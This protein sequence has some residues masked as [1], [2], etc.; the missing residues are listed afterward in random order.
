MD[1]VKPKADDIAL[2]KKK[3]LFRPCKTK[4]DL[5]NWVITFLGVELPDCT[6]SPESNSNPMDLLWEMYSVALTNNDDDAKHVNRVM[7]YAARGAG[8]TLVASILELLVML[9]TRRNITHMAA[10]KDQA[11]VS[12]EYI[13]D[14]FD[15]PYIAPFRTSTNVMRLEIERYEHVETK[16]NLTRKE[17]GE[18]PLPDRKSYR[19]YKNKV[20][21]VICTLSGV[22]G[23]HS[24]FMCVDEVD[25][26]PTHHEKAYHQSN[27]IPTTKRGL[28]PFTLLTSTRK[29]GIGLVQREIDKAED[30]GLILRH[31]N[32]IDVTQA[33]PPS[34]HQPDKPMTDMYIRDSDLEVWSE[35]RYSQASPSVQAGFEKVAAYAGCLNCKL[36][37]ACKG[38]LAT[39]QTFVPKD[40]DQSMVRPILEVIG[41]FKSS[42]IN[43]II[44]DMLCRKPDESGM[45]YPK[46]SRAVHAKTAA[47]MAAIVLGEDQDEGKWDKN[48]LLKLLLDRG[49]EFY[50]GMD[51]GMT[52][53]FAVTMMAVWGG[54]GLIV[55]VLSEPGLELDDKI[56]VCGKYLPFQPTCFGDPESPSDI[57]TFKRKGGF[58][59]REW[60]KG[61]GSVKA[62][63]ESVR[64]KLRP[65]GRSPELYYLKDDPGVELLMEDIRTYGFE[66][67][68]TGQV[69]ENPK[70]KDDDRLDSMRYVVMN[71]FAPNGV[72]RVMEPPKKT[73]PPPTSPF[74][75]TKQ[76][77]SEQFK[78]LIQSIAPDDDLFGKKDKETKVQNTQT[79]GFWF[80]IA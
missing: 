67:D 61:A 6:V 69:G 24:E 7:A 31:W 41:K 71:V 34:R 12:Q 23:K 8:K 33:C 2:L 39:K 30:T 10:V 21:I 78:S 17:W 35:S 1:P 22:N 4:K 47:E 43:E 45:V 5:Q 57:K 18:L 42:P 9:H 64:M 55:D 13:R 76:T 28:V 56:A 58:R 37:S 68:A 44:T 49:A 15:N 27:Q 25:V 38:S 46:F 70:K 11:A 74:V 65:F 80:D 36:F 60:D 48:S 32:I 52:H 50:L 51:F 77:H 66:V 63:I 19:K 75:D 40:T 79:K 29:S 26:V 72:P 73:V 14:F 3:V 59:M 53:D 20:Q 62:G 54:Y 16:D